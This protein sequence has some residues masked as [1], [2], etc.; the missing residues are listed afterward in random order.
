MTQAAV[1]D[2]QK[3]CR[4]LTGLSQKNATTRATQKLP[5]FYFKARSTQHVYKKDII[6]HANPVVPNV[7]D[8]KF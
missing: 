2:K 1:S 7:W 5:E 3:G 8:P 4:G 6:W